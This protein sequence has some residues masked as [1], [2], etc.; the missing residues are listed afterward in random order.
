M[1]EK[2]YV[3]IAEFARRVDRS[4]RVIR[5]WIKQGL[6]EAQR[7]SLTPHSRIVISMNEVNRVL[8]T[9]PQGEVIDVPEAA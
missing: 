4:P 9:L 6:I 8:A 2:Q 3:T 5:Y 7:G 1:K